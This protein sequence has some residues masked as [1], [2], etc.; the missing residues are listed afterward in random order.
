MDIEV[1]YLW[2]CDRALLLSPPEGVFSRI[3]KPSLLSLSSWGKHSDIKPSWW[4][5]TGLCPVYCWSDTGSSKLSAIL[6]TLSRVCWV[7]EYDRVFHSAYC[8]PEPQGFFAELVSSQSRHSLYMTGCQELLLPW[9]SDLHPTFLNFMSF[10]LAFSSKLSQPLWL[11]SLPSHIPDAS[12]NF[13]P[14]ADLMSMLHH[15]LHW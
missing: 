7:E 1:T 4:P 12:S 10:L 13:V 11:A 8:L 14:S 2:V 3:N 9:S 15:P 6:E 5:Y